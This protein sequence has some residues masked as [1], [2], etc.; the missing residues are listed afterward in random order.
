MTKIVIGIDEV[1]R[2]CLAGPV[3]AAAVALGQNPGLRE[4]VRDSKALSRKRRELLA[5]A[6]LRDCRVGFGEASV[7]EID[8][9]NI[10]LATHLAMVRAVNALSAHG[11]ISLIVDGNDIPEKLRK[12]DARCVVGA[13]ALVPEVSAA[14]IVAKVGRDALMS[15]LAREFPAYGWERNAGYGT[16]EH[17]RAI[18][19]HGLT[20]WHRRSFSMGI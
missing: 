4:Q 16:V 8:R 12:F 20:P 14:S 13:D 3:W 11:D 7:V 2:G 18:R 10:R 5:E 17:R 6:I 15:D 9:L 1:G 19:C